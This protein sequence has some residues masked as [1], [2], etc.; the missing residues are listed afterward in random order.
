[1]Q[2]P[3]SPPPFTK[4]KKKRKKW[5]VLFHHRLSLHE[6][7]FYFLPHARV[8][9]KGTTNSLFFSLSSSTK[10]MWCQYVAAAAA[11]SVVPFSF[12]ER[13]ARRR[14]RRIT[15]TSTSVRGSGGNGNSAGRGE[16]WR[17]PSLRRRHHHH[18]H[19][20]HRAHHREEEEEEKENE[21][22]N[23]ALFSRDVSVKATVASCAAACCILAFQ[24]VPVLDA[25]PAMASSA[26]E[27]S[28][29]TTDGKNL[30]NGAGGCLGCH[31]AG[32][33][34]LDAGKT[35]SLR[36]LTKN[37]MNGKED[38]A[39]VISLGKNKM[40]GYG[41]QCVGKLKCTFAKRLT[42]KEI[43]DL[44]EFVW[45]TANNESAVSWAKALK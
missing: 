21:N 22:E 26:T 37:G 41:E 13:N 35:L 30:F 44:S 29:V 15:T 27:E 36:D 3:P 33:N 45:T 19:R 2:G 6:S 9:K 32:G 34:I 14:R 28:I 25:S 43:R 1:M 23:D 38:V 8:K 42:E 16:P 10:K 5:L 20:R 17:R 39:E 18:H 31:P 24:T 11:A 40:P 12:E 4:V 7:I